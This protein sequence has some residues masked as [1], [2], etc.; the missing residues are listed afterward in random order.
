VLFMYVIADAVLESARAAIS[1]RASITS[2]RR[3]GSF[4]DFDDE[5]KPLGRR[6]PPQ[7]PKRKTRARG[8]SRA[9]QPPR[10]S[11]RV[12]IS[13]PQVNATGV[14]RERL[15]ADQMPQR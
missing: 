2:S 11:D 10:P 8:G 7:K 12:G 5:T 4:F 6:P 14:S 13:Q 15:P 9:G 3:S 1:A